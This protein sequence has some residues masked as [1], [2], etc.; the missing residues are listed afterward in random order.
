MVDGGATPHNNPA[1]AL[2]LLVLLQEHGISWPM[3]RDNLTIVSIGTGSF[4]PPAINYH[5]GLLRRLRLAVSALES[6]IDDSSDLVPNLMQLF[7]E[8]W[9]VEDHND[10]CFTVKDHDGRALAYVYYEEG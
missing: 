4:R 1:L 5:T 9:T 7:G 8:T 10:A 2:L 6:L 3:G